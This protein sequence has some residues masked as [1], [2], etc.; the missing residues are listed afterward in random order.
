MIDTEKYIKVIVNPLEPVKQAQTVVINNLDI[1]ITKNGV[2]EAEQPYTGYGKVTVQVSDTP[3]V[4]NPL[5]ITPST[6]QQTITASGGVDGYSPIT[7]SAVTSEI[8]SNITAGN[9]KSGVTIL[10]VTGTYTPSLPYPYRKMKISDNI[11]YSDTTDSFAL[12]FGSLAFTDVSFYALNCIGYNLIHTGNISFDNLTAVSGERAFNY[13]FS[14]ANITG[15]M[16]FNNLTSANG[17]YAFYYAFYGATVSQGIEFNSLV[18]L[19]S[20]SSYLFYYAFSWCVGNVYFNNL[21]TVNANFCFNC[22]FSYMKDIV[23]LHKLKTVTG[24]YAFQYAFQGDQSTEVENRQAPYISGLFSSLESITS[25]NAFRCAFQYNNHITGAITFSKLNTINNNNIFYYA[26]RDCINITSL[27]F[28]ALTSTSFDSYTTQ[29]DNMLQ[30]C[31]DV[32]V[33][34]PSN[35]QSVIGSW[36]SVTAGFNGTNTTVLFDLPATT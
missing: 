35:L 27:S 2:Y 28:P 34:F 20:N 17:Y 6:N 13:A 31:T 3:V 11:L 9:I 4:I 25:N 5:S 21:E 8:D 15:K 36:A 18:T 30:N 23:Y 12:D 33:H 29:F 1:T 32:I 16:T 26:F 24:S 10:G 7:V 14:N 22:S 19:T